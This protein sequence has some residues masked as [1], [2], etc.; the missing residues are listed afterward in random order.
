MNIANDWVQLL[1]PLN[2]VCHH[3]QLEILLM[4][5]NRCVRFGFGGITVLVASSGHPVSFNTTY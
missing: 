2:R 4:R 1:E 5:R 3:S